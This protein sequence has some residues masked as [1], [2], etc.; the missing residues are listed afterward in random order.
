MTPAQHVRLF[1]KA[2]HGAASVLVAV[3]MLQLALGLDFEGKPFL[4]FAAAVA[5]VWA[6]ILISLLLE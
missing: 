4:V 5:I 3:L 1:W 2:C 6:G